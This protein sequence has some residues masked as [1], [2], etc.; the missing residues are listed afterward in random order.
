MRNNHKVTLMV[1]TALFLLSQPATSSRLRFTFTQTGFPEGSVITGSFEGEDLNNDGVLKQQIDNEI[2]EVNVEFS[3]TTS[4]PAFSL[5]FVK[6]RNDSD[7]MQGLIYGLDGGPLGELNNSEGIGII[8][9]GVIS[10]FFVYRAGPGPVNQCGIG[11]NCGIIGPHFVGS[12]NQIFSD[13]V[14]TVKQVP[15]EPI[16]PNA[17]NQVSGFV[18][19]DNNADGLQ[20][21]NEPGF[22][23]IIPGFRSPTVALYPVGSTE[24][25]DVTILDEAS[26]GEYVF[27]HVSDGEYYVC[28]S[29][30]FLI[31]DLSIS[32]QDAGDDTIDS[33]FDGS[34]CSYGITVNSQQ[35]AVRDLGLI[36]GSIDPGQPTQP[37][38]PIDPVE[39]TQPTSG[40]Q[41][42]GFVWLDNNADGLQTPGEPGYAQT[43]ADFGA[44]NVELYNADSG[45]LI[46]LSPLDET[47]NGLYAFENLSAGTYFICVSNQFLELDLTVTT[48][49][50][51]GDDSIDSDFDFSPCAY[52]IVI[53]GQQVETR[54]LGL[55]GGSTDPGQPTDPVEP[56]NPATGNQVS[57][58]V[59]LDNNADG[60][61]TEGEPGFSQT[62]TDVGEMTVALY[63]QGSF[64]FIN[65][66]YLEE[67]GNGHYLFENVPTG[68]Y[69][70]CAN[71]V[72][73]LIG[74]SVTNQDSGDDAIDSD[75]DSSPC[76]YG[77]TV[78]AEQGAVRDLGLVG[79]S[80]DPV[81]PGQ[82]T[83]PTDPVNPT[84]PVDPVNPTIPTSGNQISGFVWHDKNGDGLQNMNELAFTQTIPE[85]T[86]L[87]I[88]VYPE[89]SVTLI[90]TA[91]L[92]DN[93]K[94]RY[95]FNNLPAGNYYL[96]TSRL[97]EELGLSVTTQNAGN[98]S[99]DNDFDFSACSFGISVSAEQ[100]AV[101]DMGLAG[102]ITPISSP[103]TGTLKGT[104]WIDRNN[105]GL[106]LDRNEVGIGNITLELYSTNQNQPIATTI[107]TIPVRTSEFLNTTFQFENLNAGTYV[108]CAIISPDINPQTTITQQNAGDEAFDNDF[109][110]ETSCTNSQV[111]IAQ[112]TTLV[113]L[114]L[115]VQPNTE[116]LLVTQSCS[117]QSAIHAATYGTPVNGC[118][119]GV[120]PGEDT[121]ILEPN[122]NHP[123]FRVHD[124]PFTPIL[125]RIT[126]EGNGAFIDA[127]NPFFF[128]GGASLVLNNLTVDTINVTGHKITLNN[129]TVVSD[130]Q[131]IEP[132]ITVTITNSL[133]C[134]SLVESLTF[135]HETRHL[136][137][138]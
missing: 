43:V 16:I 96:C 86:A 17:A 106:Q 67:G 44:P 84:D 61:Q 130:I 123:S 91:F 72:F 75:F 118:F 48:T 13:D 65:V 76:S 18:W 120:Y 54:D 102:T 49:D 82:P 77:I 79:G 30:E 10:P 128:T 100:G 47:S 87:S 131:T 52:G 36:G 58:F 114:G 74:L 97:Y 78:N 95:Q 20:S 129:S 81:D 107:S 98:D 133:I 134:G 113:G 7:R 45:D 108:V 104:V 55:V 12:T 122:S 27:K 80:I 59:W 92:D 21:I 85:L 105:D 2:S 124:A 33:D 110:S 40:N 11:L 60:L 69:Y 73:D 5:N 24:L 14:V 137:P 15:T 63:P 115:V 25:I 68:T 117:L 28:V 51:G 31:L 127:I 126:I 57:G 116:S 1:L 112:H 88:S 23:Q 111:V 70:L 32:P 8:E 66:A 19:L 22:N 34:P 53:S 50:V 83:D 109:N 46:G 41:I 99:I 71:R 4:F 3:G 119:S 132:G 93:S 138:C 135:S 125:N 94:G 6:N 89:N 39:P 9:S 56:T 101:R 103:G 38:D 37:T 29:N 121:I 42:N 35:G 62:I 26:N 64:E 136:N 90:E